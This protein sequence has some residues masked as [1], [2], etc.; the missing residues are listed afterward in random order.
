MKVKVK[1]CGIRTLKSAKTALEAGADFLGF[2]FVPSLNRFISY[3]GAKKI[4]SSLPKNIKTV[5]IFQNQPIKL[6]NHL[7]S[8]L[9][10]KFVQLHGDED[11]QFYQ[12]INQVKIIKAICLPSNFNHKKVLSKL[13]KLDSNYFLLD[14]KNRKSG[15]PLN[16]LAVKKISKSFPIFLAG[17]L[18]PENVTQAVKTVKPFAVDVASGIETGDKQD[19][20]K[21]K[22]F[23]KN[24]KQK[25]KI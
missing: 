9:N 2:N 22:A 25:T 21:I 3:Q 8:C 6:I 16:L 11:P 1:I 23:I 19:M 7:I 17:G 12:L 13:K 14:R 20:I 15:K 24:A 10:L 4:I 5:G 18:T